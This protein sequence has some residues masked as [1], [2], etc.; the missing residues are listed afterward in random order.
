MTDINLWTCMTDINLWAPHKLW[1]AFICQPSLSLFIS[2]FSQKQNNIAK[3]ILS[4]LN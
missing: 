4:N 3:M 2:R 1:G